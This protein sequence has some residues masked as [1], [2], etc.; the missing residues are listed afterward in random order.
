MKWNVK[1]KIYPD[2]STNTIFCNQKIF[3]DTPTERKSEKTTSETD[4]TE[5]SDNKSLNRKKVLVGK[6]DYSLEVRSDSLKRAKDKIQDICLCN[7][8]D[9]FVT[10][11]FN[12]DKVDSFDVEQVKKAIKTWLNNG[13]ARRGYKYIAIPEYHKS[14][15]IHLHALMSGD[16]D[17]VDSGHKH[18][19]KIIYNIADWQEKFGF[20]TAIPIDGNINSLAYYITKYITKGNDKIFGRFYWSSRN[21]QREP[22]LEY[23]NTDFYYVNQYE[24]EVPGTTRKLKYE[25]DFKF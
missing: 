22:D 11:T 4:G 3:N 15:R 13:V 14:G 7:K 6:S 18:Y 12:P 19:N 23:R 10:L 9:Y 16:L 17:L 24:Y 20:C 5:K 1:C 2:G 21:L 8:F 25:A